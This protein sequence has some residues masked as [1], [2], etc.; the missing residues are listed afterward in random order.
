MFFAPYLALDGCCREA[1]TRY[2]EIFGGELMISTHGE[3]PGG[4]ELGA[5]WQDV[6]MHARLTT[7][8]TILMGSDQRPGEHSE[9]TGFSLSSNPETAEEAE[10]IFSELSEGGT[11]TMPLGETFWA[12]RFGMLKDQFGV[13]WMINCDFPA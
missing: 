1:F 10:R 5:E 2:A 12:L 4:D 13:P 3:A 9:L 8:K 7:P 11:I 6:V